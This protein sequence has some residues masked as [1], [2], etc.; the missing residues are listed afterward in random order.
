[1]DFLVF[2]VLVRMFFYGSVGRVVGFPA[3]GLQ[4]KGTAGCCS[5]ALP[6]THGA[7][8]VSGFGM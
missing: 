6:C 1:M 2:F 8:K 3:L 4:G 5:C 7:F